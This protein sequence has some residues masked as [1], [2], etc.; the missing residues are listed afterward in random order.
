MTDWNK[1]IHK[2]PDDHVWTCKPG[3]NIFVGSAGA[4]RFDIPKDWIVEPTSDSIM[5]HDTPAP[6]DDCR[7]QVS[8]IHV[9]PGIDWSALPL[10]KLLDDA[11]LKDDPRDLTLRRTPKIVRRPDLE[12]AWVESQFIDPNEKREAR[13]RSCLARGNDIQALITFDYWPEH[14]Q[15][16]VPVW[17]EV[18]RTLRLG[19]YVSGFEGR[20]LYRG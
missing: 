20:R 15:R 13:T 9:P 17:N 3:Y 8:I 14:V 1:S 6:D 18:L 2:L 5:F 10:T 11:V 7:L 4:I 19:E 16:F 12:L